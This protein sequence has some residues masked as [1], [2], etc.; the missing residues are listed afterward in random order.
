MSVNVE[1]VITGVTPHGPLGVDVAYILSESTTGLTETHTDF[2]LSA[3]LN[4][5]VTDM[6]DAD[7][8]KAQIKANFLTVTLAIFTLFATLVKHTIAQNL[9]QTDLSAVTGT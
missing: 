1:Y 9:A 8:A 4:S 2:M 7:T 6:M 5:G 3:T